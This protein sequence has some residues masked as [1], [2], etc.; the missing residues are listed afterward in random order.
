MLDAKRKMSQKTY[1]QL[2]RRKIELEAEIRQRGAAS[3]GHQRASIHDDAGAENELNLLRAD[4]NRIGNLTYVDII[5]P[6]EATDTVNLGNEIV[7]QYEGEE[8]PERFLVLGYDDN[9]FRD[10]LKGRVITPESPIGKAVLG[11]KPGEE[12]SFEASKRQVTVEIRQVL[13]GDF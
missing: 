11:K 13:K 7:V 2:T 9:V 12:A 5:Q 3:S 4:L 8:T 1:E 6:R 10:D